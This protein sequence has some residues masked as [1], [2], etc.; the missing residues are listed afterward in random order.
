MTAR[1]VAGQF[2]RRESAVVGDVAHG[3]EHAV[4]NS[5]HGRG[6]HE[7]LGVASQAN[8]TGD[9]GL[10]RIEG[11]GGNGN[12]GLPVLFETNVLWICRS[13]AETCST[14]RDLEVI[15][16]VAFGS[17]E[18]GLGESEGV[19]S[20]DLCHLVTACNGLSQ[21]IDPVEAEIAHSSRRVLVRR[22]VSSLPSGERIRTQ[23]RRRTRDVR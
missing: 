9:E 3:R 8:S 6:R 1:S 4:E 23:R 10:L 7:F 19:I 5:E 12:S 14:I 21:R 17:S 15:G 2:R 18:N 20:S 22:H 11:V 16:D 13:C